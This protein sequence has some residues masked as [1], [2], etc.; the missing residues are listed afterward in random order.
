MVSTLVAMVTDLGDSAVLVPISLAV[1][2]LLWLT[3]DRRTA[4]AWAMAIGVC[5]VATVVLKVALRPCDRPLITDV[6]QNPSG[7]AAFSTAVYGALTLLVVGRLRGRR[8]RWAALLLGIVWIAAIAASRVAESAH[9]IAEI[10]LGVAIGAASLLVFAAAGHPAP[11]SRRSLAL[12]GV[13][14]GIV[15]IAQLGHR[16]PAERMIHQ[17]AWLIYDTVGLCRATGASLE[18]GKLAGDAPTPAVVSWAAWPDDSQ[19]PRGEEW[20][21]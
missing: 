3:H 4:F 11:K 20:L 5:C 15:L 2:I 10:V 13:L 8:A 21:N 17:L 16:A 14:I 9:T 7:H 18:D 6:L 1:F 12:I 19:A